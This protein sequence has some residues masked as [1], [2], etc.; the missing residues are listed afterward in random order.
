[1]PLDLINEFFNQNCKE[2]MKNGH[3]RFTAKQA[4]RTSKLIGT[5]Q[6]GLDQAF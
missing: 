4:R 1:M 2:N 6:T 3:G 5:V